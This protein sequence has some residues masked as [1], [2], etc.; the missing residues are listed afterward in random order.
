MQA[1][2][3]EQKSF[4]LNAW[5]SAGKQITNPGVLARLI[6]WEDWLRKGVIFIGRPIFSMSPCRWPENQE[7]SY[8]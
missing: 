2:L 1:I 7:R 3:W 4:L 6:F 5:S 8:L